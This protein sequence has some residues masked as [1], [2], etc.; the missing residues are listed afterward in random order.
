M[1]DIVAAPLPV[2]WPSTASVTP[3]VPTGR[4]RVLAT[5]GA[6][7]TPFFPESP[8]L[9]EAGVPGIA[10]SGWVALLGPA[11]LPTAIAER[12]HALLQG[13]FADPGFQGRLGTLG[14]EPDLRPA[15]AL[16]DEM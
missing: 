5:A 12:L 13:A 16:R 8:T 10:L 9:A 11:A 14:I 3:H 2:E 4:I 7:R 15:G 1:N 6:S